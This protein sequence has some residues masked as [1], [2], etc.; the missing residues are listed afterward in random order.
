[1]LV[2][3]TSSFPFLILYFLLSLLHRD[4]SQRHP[5]PSLPVKEAYLPILEVAAWG[6]DLRFNTQPGAHC[7]SLGSLWLSPAP[8]WVGG[9][10]LERA[11]AQSCC[12]QAVPLDS[13]TLVVSGACVRGFGRTEANKREVFG[14]LSSWGSA[15]REQTEASISQPFPEKGLS[16]HFT[17][18]CPRAS[19]QSACIQMLPEVL[20]WGHWQ[21]L[22]HHQWLRAT[23]DKEGCL[24]NHK[25]WE[26]SQS[27]GWAKW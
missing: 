6:P 20:L 24:N 26:T 14:W 9:V 3:T 4:S 21:V 12:P 27:W 19:F 13:L 17:S 15:Q 25:G 10:S 23:N 5:G 22:A 18:G 2:S 8:L 1:M 7:G 11:C 16:A